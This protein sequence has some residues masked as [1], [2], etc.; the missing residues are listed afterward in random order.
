MKKLE[1]FKTIQL[2]VFALLAAACIAFLILDRGVYHA[3][4]ANPK[5]RIVT[6]LLWIVMAAQFLFL[7]LDFTLYNKY[8]KNVSDLSDAVHSDPKTDI[9]NRLSCDEMIE[10]YL[11]QPLPKDLGC[12]M[13]DITN[14]REVNDKY[15]HLNGNKMIKRFST[16]LKLASV[17]HCFVG[18][19]GGN[20]FLA[21][22]E[23][24]SSESIK[25]FLKRVQSQV[26][27]NN[28]TDGAIPIEYC[29]GIAFHEPEDNDADD[30]TSL[31]ALSSRRARAAEKKINANKK[32]S[33]WERPASAPEK[34][35][36]A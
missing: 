30:I 24:G 25:A 12:V 8:E 10:K 34:K 20:Q 3:V 17:D 33:E 4:A 14:I 16:I 22:F 27:L 19:N 21:L 18:R 15:G 2:V 13:L 5:L 28:N 9:A 11:D 35:A 31:I 26:A 7:F 23:E 1:K 36:D 32:T 6:T 29:A